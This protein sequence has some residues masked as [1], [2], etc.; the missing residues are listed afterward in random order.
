MGSRYHPTIRCGFCWGPIG[1]RVEHDP[2]SRL[3]CALCD[4]WAGLPEV[5]ASVE[6]FERDHARIMHAT[7]RPTARPLPPYRRYRFVPEP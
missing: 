1:H 4:N 3:G 6:R 7:H 5:A 2:A